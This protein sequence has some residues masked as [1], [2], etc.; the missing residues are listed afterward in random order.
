M[1]LTN[2]KKLAQHIFR[3]LKVNEIVFSI[4]RTNKGNL[5][6]K[7][8]QNSDDFEIMLDAVPL[9]VK[10]IIDDDNNI[11]LKRMLEKYWFESKVINIPPPRFESMKELLE[12]EEAPIE[13]RIH[14]ALHSKKI[15]VLDEAIKEIEEEIKK[16][17]KHKGR[18]KGSKNRPKNNHE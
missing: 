13:N 7:F 16:V 17:K 10:S 15:E 8:T 9:S 11:E 1:E 2:Q 4:G 14:E 12:N 6:L 18:P 5:G 3:L